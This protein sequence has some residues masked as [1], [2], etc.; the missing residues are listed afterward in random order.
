[1]SSPPVILTGAAHHCGPEPVDDAAH[2]ADEQQRG[3]QPAR[4]RLAQLEHHAPR[5]AQHTFDGGNKVGD[6]HPFAEV[7]AQLVAS[8]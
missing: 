7:L 2:D 1:M 3:D 4:P 8:V 5:M 6:G